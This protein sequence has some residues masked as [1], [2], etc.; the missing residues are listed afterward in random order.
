MTLTNDQLTALIEM[1]ARATKDLKWLNSEPIHIHEGDYLGNTMI[2]LSS[3]Y[4]GDQID[5]R[6]IEKIL[7]AAPALLKEVVELRKEKDGLRLCIAILLE[8][9]ECREDEDCDH[10]HV[11]S[12]LK[13]FEKLSEGVIE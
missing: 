9:A 2:M 4:E 12:I 10:C 13:S 5:C 3:N 1:E 7:D 8:N 11:E 6:Y